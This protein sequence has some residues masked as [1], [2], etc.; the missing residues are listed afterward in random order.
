[1]SLEPVGHLLPAPGTSSPFVPGPPRSRQVVPDL[2]LRFPGGVRDVP[3]PAAL[4]DPPVGKISAPGTLGAG[5][6]GTLCCSVSPK[7]PQDKAGFE[8]RDLGGQ[9]SRS[10]AGVASWGLPG[11]GGSTSPSGLGGS[12]DEASPRGLWRPSRANDALG[13]PGSVICRRSLRERHRRD[14]EIRRHRVPP[15]G[16]SPSS[17]TSTSPRSTQPFDSDPAPVTRLFSV[18]SAMPTSA[19]RGWGLPGI[20]G[21]NSTR[22]ASRY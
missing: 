7:F 1:M 9:M 13:G 10:S 5:L 20:R 22:E 3:P 15:C 2:R 21:Q 8:R 6:T 17:R 19:G 14:N 11:R 4:V 16:H 18:P 12:G